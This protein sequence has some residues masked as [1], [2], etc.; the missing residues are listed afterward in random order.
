MFLE[1]LCSDSLL[2][3]GPEK[4]I[5]RSLEDSFFRL[6][7]TGIQH[8]VEAQHATRPV[9]WHHNHLAMTRSAGIGHSIERSINHLDDDL[10]NYLGFILVNCGTLRVKQRNS[11]KTVRTGHMIAVDFRDSFAMESSDGN[12]IF[13]F[14]ISRSYLES[15][16]V[17]S[18]ILD[19]KIWQAPPTI[20]ALIHLTI[21]AIKAQL[22]GIKYDLAAVERAL[23]ELILN[24]ITCTETGYTVTSSNASKTR[25]QIMELVEAGFKD[26]DFGVDTLA[27]VLRMSKRQI[28]R[29]FEGQQS[30]IAGIIRKRRLEHAELLLTSV[31]HLSLAQVGTLS[32]FRSA[33]QFSRAFKEQHDI[34]PSIYRNSPK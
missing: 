12:E 24:I 15:R 11:V 3:D 8:G 25:A 23:L 14:H 19:A 31:H 33:D 4:S 2:Q 13:S 34:L 28:Y 26:V 6:H 9:V 20:M 17:D 27:D 22:Q 21:W 30:T 10:G 7:Q 5:A 16:G 32:G 29:L 1:K 18:M